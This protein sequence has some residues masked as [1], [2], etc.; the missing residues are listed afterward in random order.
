MSTTKK[1]QLCKNNDWNNAEKLYIVILC[2]VVMA[3]LCGHSSTIPSLR[4]LYHHS[5]LRLIC[6]EN[7]GQYTTH[8]AAEGLR[9]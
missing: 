2:V 7:L 6:T 3:W 5:A 4:W 9:N 1:G 8:V